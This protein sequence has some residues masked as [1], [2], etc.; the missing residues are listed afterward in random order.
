MISVPT[1]GNNTWYAAVGDLFAYASAV[2][3]LVLAG[4]ALRPKRRR[5]DQDEG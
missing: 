4:M 3:L 2:G 5:Q 1:Q